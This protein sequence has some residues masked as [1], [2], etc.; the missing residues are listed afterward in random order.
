MDRL[1]DHLF[2]FEGDGVIRDFPGNYGQYREQVKDPPE[3][4]EKKPEAARPAEPTPAKKKLTYKEQREFD[5]LEKEIAELDAERKNIYNRMSQ[6]NLPYDEIR[7]LT[8]RIGVLNEAIDS[9]E[10]RW[11]ELSENS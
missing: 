7:A 6:N 3:P 9:K 4:E 1:V 8:A 2:V 10:M 5:M 11:L